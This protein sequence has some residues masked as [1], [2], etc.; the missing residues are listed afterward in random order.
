V[1]T[2]D[3]MGNRLQRQDSAVGTTNYAYNAANMLL[4]TGGAGASGFQNDADGNTLSGNG[5]TNAWDSQ[6]RLVSCIINGNTTAYR[7]GADGL[8]RQATKNGASTDYAYDGTMLVREGHATGGSLTPST[9]TATYLIGARG[10]EYRRD[11]TQTEIDSQ[12]RTV[13]KARWYVFD[14]L[15]SVVGEVDASG[16]L[17]SSPKYDVYGAVRANGG[18]ASSK[19]G[20]VGSLGHASDDTGLVYMQARYYDPATGRFASEDTG[21]QGTNWFV[22]CNDN[23]VNL[24]DPNG[25]FPALD[26]VLIVIG[27]LLCMCPGAWKYVGAILVVL[28]LAAAASD[29]YE[30]SHSKDKDT[31]QKQHDDEQKKIK[32]IQRDIDSSSAIGGDAGTAVAIHMLTIELLIADED[33]TS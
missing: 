21:R 29:I 2:F 10:P 11:D 24:V 32:D 5:R 13:T 18:T 30:A 17:T 26:V 8:R 4:S 25:C 33:D 20:F 15:G 16:N 3:A 19:Q 22:Y 12:G 6:N 7:Y 27:V 23:P 28:G 14:G 1:Y 31:I 9:V